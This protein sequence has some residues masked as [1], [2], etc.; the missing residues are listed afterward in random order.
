MRLA[1]T[2]AA[3]ATPAAGA[4]V[5]IVRIS[6]GLALEVARC[7]FSGFPE[8][9]EPRRLYFGA[10]IDPIER[11][12]VDEGFGVFMPGPRSFTGEN[13]C[14]LQCHGGALNL[15]RVLEVVLRSGA[16]AAEPGEFTRRAFIH[17]R[18]DLAQAE[19]VLDVIDARTVR[20]HA[21]A[22]AQLE[23]GLSASVGALRE[24]L[25]GVLA[26]LEV[27]I[28]FADEHVPDVPLAGLAAQ[29]EAVQRD[30]RRLSETFERGRIAREGMH[31][32]LAGLPNAGKSSLFN[33]LLREP[34]AI[35]TD[36][37]GTTRDFLEE[38]ADLGGVPIVL[39]D[40]AGLR[41]T[42]DPVE[43]IGVER[44]S[45]RIHQAAA[46]LCVH[47]G[48][49]PPSQADR[50]VRARVPDVLRLDVLSKCD[51]PAAPGWAHELPDAVAVSAHTGQGLDALVGA[52]LARAGADEAGS[53][54]LVTRARHKVALDR[55]SEALGGARDACADMLPWEIVAGEV[56]LALAALGDI[57]GA[58]TTEDVLDRI[59]S[60]F[61][62][63][64]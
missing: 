28:D 6:G 52:L 14:E 62:L 36:V 3:V 61:C 37:P 22:Q 49:Q 2:I 53:A 63:G 7:A 20:G 13:V 43:R 47:D 55:A 19:A 54:P 1:E 44:S 58:T 32:A 9:P 42:L 24:R 45:A 30:V 11:C 41:E 16:R 56:Q 10:I 35:V 34:R 25:I 8:V 46:V 60:E 57:V 59:F 26:H 48:T 40:T 21:A 29:V 15:R 64:K 39:I 23:G 51:L 31:V 33:A 38:R 50:A 12:R 5:G 27:Q 4:G 17:G 18:L